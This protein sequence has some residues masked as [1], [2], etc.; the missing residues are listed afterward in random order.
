MSAKTALKKSV[1]AAS[2]LI[3]RIAVLAIALFQI[4]MLYVVYGLIFL[5]LELH[6]SYPYP[7]F[8]K[9]RWAL[10]QFLSHTKTSHI[11][12]S[13]IFWPLLNLLAFPLERVPDEHELS[14]EFLSS[15][16]SKAV[17]LRYEGKHL[18]HQG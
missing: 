17:Q 9:S 14:K 10:N 7:G 13:M 8:S 18:A 15:S 4:M 1:I 11:T 2:Y 12:D 6:K 5:L 16:F 3:L